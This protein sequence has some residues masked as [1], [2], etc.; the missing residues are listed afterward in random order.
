MIPCL[1][2]HHCNRLALLSQGKEFTY[3]QLSAL[4]C[5]AKERYGLSAHPKGQPVA[6]I[7]ESS[8]ESL[9]LFFAIWREGLIALPL[10]PRWPKQAT[11]EA[12]I[13][14]G[15]RLLQPV[16]SSKTVAYPEG[17]LN[18]EA[19]ATMLFTS[20]TTGSPKIA[21]HSLKNHLESAKSAAQLLGI[22]KESRYLLSL[23][24]SHVGGIAAMLRTFLV[25][26]TL[27]LAPPCAEPTHLSLVPTQLRRLVKNGEAP[28][29]T[30]CI[31][32]GGACL[33]TELLEEALSQKLPIYQSYGLTETASL[34]ALQTPHMARTQIAEGAELKIEGGEIYVRGPQ[35]FRGYFKKGEPSLDLPLVDG[36]FATGDLGSMSADGTLKWLGRKDRRFKSGGETIQPE[37]IEAL[38]LEVPGIVEAYVRPSPHEEFGQCPHAFVFCDEE[39]D[40]RA[41][42]RQLRQQ[43]PGYKIPKRWEKL[44]DPLKG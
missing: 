12:L 16:L 26:A 24:L 8:S 30:R 23:P 14:T 7:A 18:P 4:V 43:L 36:W 21:C 13:L 34:I 17:N 9:A 33:S 19:L 40:L 15:A 10:S 28:K 20:G 5:E 38:L 1:L 25:G 35:L 22:E 3:K 29:K 31:L 44:S 11:E 41:V 39:V 6:F 2:E 27:L 37:E 42:E 32:V